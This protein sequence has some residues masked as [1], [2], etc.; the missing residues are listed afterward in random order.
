MDDFT[1]FTWTHLL[2]SKKEVVT[3]FQQFYVYVE[4]QFSVKILSIS[5]DNAKVLIEGDM[6]T[7][8]QVLVLTHH[9][10]MV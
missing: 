7:F 3:V 9:N 4:T 6:K 5:S 10:K 1:R 2:K 8:C